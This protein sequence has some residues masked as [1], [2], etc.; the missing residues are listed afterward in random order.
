MPSDPFTEYGV[1]TSF[2]VGMIHGVGAETPTQ[3]LLFA[4]AAGVAGGA[5]GVVLLTVFV[6][7]LLLANT[8]VAIAASRGFSAGQRLPVVFIALAGLTA[9]ASLAIG[10]LYL[11][12]RGDLI[13]ALLGG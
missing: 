6:A 11:L 13:P 1:W 3:V 7:G 9:A 10:T 12:G 4:T 2:G 5:A 8:V